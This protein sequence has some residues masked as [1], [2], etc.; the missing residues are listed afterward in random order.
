ML[1]G[2]VG[3]IKAEFIGGWAADTE[4]PNSVVDVIVYIDGKRATH[5]SCDHFRQDLL[6]LGKYGEGRHGF[7]WRISP[8]LP[9]DLLDRISVRFARTGA[10]L[11]GGE[12]MRLPRQGDLSPILITAPG[13]SGTTLMM[14]RL[15]LSP[16]ICVAESHPFEVRLIA[17][18]ST[19]V[20]ILAAEADYERST[21]PDKLEGDGFRVGSNPYSHD[22]FKGAFAE[23][24]LVKGYFNTYV[25]AEINDF[26]R[27]MILEYYSRICDDRRKD[28]ASLFAEKNNNLDRRPRA[29]VRGLYPNMKEI[30]LV[31]DPRDLLCSHLSYFGSQPELALRHISLATRELTRLKHEESDHVLVVRYEDMVLDAE[32]T[33]AR[34]ATYLNIPPFFDAGNVKEKAGF[35]VHAT[36]AS[37]EESIGRWKLQLPPAQQVVCKRT[38]EAFLT[39][40]GYSD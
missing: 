8:P 30:V 18:W 13:R 11:P 9:L 36:S 33:F 38:W 39:E 17:Y 23:P 7:Q 15:A 21:H 40:F 29:F 37:P 6:D 14:G 22:N 5:L 2:H 3:Q 20:R 1:V 28:Q 31:R 35:G 26:A 19:V 24:A 10:V 4:A 32:A 25:P 16:L 27:R 12:M 34:V